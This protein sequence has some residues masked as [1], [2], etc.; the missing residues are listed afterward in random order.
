MNHRSN[1]KI[2]LPFTTTTNM[3]NVVSFNIKA[4]KLIDLIEWKHHEKSIKFNIA[5]M[6]RRDNQWQKAKI[7]IWDR[8]RYIWKDKGTKDKRFWL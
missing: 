8:R 1:I 6:S 2:H 7:E 3:Y 4:Q 5:E